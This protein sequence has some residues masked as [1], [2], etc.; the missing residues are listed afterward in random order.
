MTDEVGN[1][2]SEPEEEQI[3]QG[4]TLTEHLEE[5]RRRVTRCAVAVFVGF[6]AC[7]G[8]SKQLFDVLMEPM[9]RILKRSMASEE[10]LPTDFF[11][12]L[13]QALD[14]GLQNTGF[15]Y[16]DRLPTFIDLL[17]RSME[18]AMETGY[19]QYTSPPEAF[20]TYIKISVVAGIFLVSPYLFYQVWGFVAPGLYKHERRWLIPIAFFSAFFFVTGALFGYFVVFPFGFEFFAGFTTPDI[21]FI[22]KLNEYLSFALKLLFAFGIAFE[23]PLFILFL[24]RLGLVTAAGLRKRRKYAILITFIVAAILTP[25]DPFTQTLMAIPMLFLYEIGIIVAKLFGKRKEKPE[26]EEPAEG[27]GKQAASPE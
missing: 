21:Q 15:P 7:Y 12:Q 6:I 9:N 16:T 5:L 19:F 17:R 18:R 20:F 23:L 22:P 2:T 1:G 27:S 26:P 25:P 3:E 8:F 24:A 13:A 4:M 14:K 10:L 11:E